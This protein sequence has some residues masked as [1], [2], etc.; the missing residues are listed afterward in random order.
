MAEDSFFIQEGAEQ[1][2]IINLQKEIS[3]LSKMYKVI[4]VVE[5]GDDVLFYRPLVAEVFTKIGNITTLDIGF[6]VTSGKS[7][8]LALAEEINSRPTRYKTFQNNQH[9]YYMH[10]VDRDQDSYLLHFAKAKL[11]CENFIHEYPKIYTYPNVFITKYYSYESYFLEGIDSSVHQTNLYRITERITEYNQLGGGGDNTPSS[12]VE[13]CEIGVAS[14]FTNEATTAFIEKIR[15]IRQHILYLGAL[16]ILQRIKHNT[17]DNVPAINDAQGMIISQRFNTKNNLLKKIRTTSQDLTMK[18]V[19]FIISSSEEIKKEQLPSELF[20]EEDVNNIINEI[21]KLEG[22]EGQLW[23]KVFKGK[24]FS[25]VLSEGLKGI[26]LI[27]KDEKLPFVQNLK[28]IFPALT[29][30]FHQERIFPQDIKDFLE[31]NYKQFTNE[32]SA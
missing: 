17:E 23:L 8:N 7:A 32:Q 22:D 28:G 18:E 11:S 3:K 16:D 12:W 10:F 20:S 21:K 26:N 2:G 25:P 6:L 14:L 31:E 5:G 13:K 9:L 29:Y 1:E 30:Y 24:N 27:F 19:E 4:C 15:S